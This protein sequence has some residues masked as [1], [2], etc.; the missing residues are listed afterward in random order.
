M[1]MIRSL[2]KVTFP[3]ILC[4]QVLVNSV[5]GTL[6][7]LDEGLRGFG[8]KAAT[9]SERIS[10]IPD[11]ERSCKIPEREILQPIFIPHTTDEF[12]YK[13][14]KITR[15][16]SHGEEITRLRILGWKIGFGVF[17]FEGNIPQNFLDGSFKNDEN[18][19]IELESEKIEGKFCSPN[20]RITLNR[21]CSGSE[22]IDRKSFIEK[23]DLG[24]RSVGSDVLGS[25]G[26]FYLPKP[27]SS[28]ILNLETEARE[29][30]AFQEH[31]IFLSFV[32]SDLDS[33]QVLLQCFSVPVNITLEDKDSDLND[34]HLRG[35][36][37]YSFDSRV[38]HKVSYDHK[39]QFDFLDLS[40][41]NLSFWQLV[42]NHL[43]ENFA[44]KRLRK[45]GAPE[46]EA[47]T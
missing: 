19:F 29:I 38:P 21:F 31:N 32:G 9:V 20:I 25:L 10:S 14:F 26:L 40:S 5:Y 23:L 2:K 36:G 24:F 35:K 42:I 30:M 37:L 4:F 3:F 44:G 27:G 13:L 39:I 6:S 45:T 46:P 7:I 22:I 1:L 47:L 17:T 16:V 28:D 12:S 11:E 8:L 34:L 41:R 33:H 43:N 18:P 15:H